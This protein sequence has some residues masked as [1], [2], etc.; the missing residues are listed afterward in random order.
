LTAGYKPGNLIIFD[1]A[2]WGEFEGLATVAPDLILGTGIDSSGSWSGSL[3]VLHPTYK[4]LL[5]SGI[6]V[7]WEREWVDKHYLVFK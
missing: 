1:S 2:T 5:S 3:P 6:V 7:S 4:I